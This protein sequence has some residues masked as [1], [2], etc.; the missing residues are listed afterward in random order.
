MK[1]VH[2]RS[3]ALAALSMAV[4]L[5]PL[6][7]EAQTTRMPSTLRYGSGYLDVPSASVLPHLA[8]TGTFS[9]FWASVGTTPLVDDSGAIVGLDNNGLEKFYGDGSIALGL[10]DRVELGAS[11]QSF[12]DASM[13]H[14]W[15][16]RTGCASAA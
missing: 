7:V 5:L 13:Q 8:L 4:M 15:C 10:F 2:G 16:L 14:F 3:W 9:G 6:Q 12:N 11:L 1:T